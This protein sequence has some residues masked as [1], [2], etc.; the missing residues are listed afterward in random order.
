[1]KT[2]TRPQNMGTVT[3]GAQYGTD[4]IKFYQGTVQH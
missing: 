1:M 3:S 2:R 4:G